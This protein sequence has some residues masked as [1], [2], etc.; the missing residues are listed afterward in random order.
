MGRLRDL[1][2]GANGRSTVIARVGRA[3]R[4]SFDAARTTN[5]N[6]RHWQDADHLSADAALSPEVRHRLRI[7]TRHECTNNPVAAGIIDTLVNDVVASGPQ[8]QMQTDDE[9]V[10]DAVESGWES[11]GEEIDLPEKLRVIEKSKLESGEV[12][13]VLVR[14]DQLE[15][16][17]KLDLRL[18]E[19]D[20][21]AT[22][23]PR[24]LDPMTVDGLQFDAFGN[25]TGYHVLKFHPG[26]VMNV[27]QREYDTFPARDVIHYFRTM[28]P[29]QHRGYPEL[30]P[31]L[32]MLAF[33]R[34]YQLASIR[35]AEAV[36]ELGAIVL[37]TELPP[38]IDSDLPTPLSTIDLERG[39]ITTL[40]F[41]TKA[42]QMRPE[43]PAST[44]DMVERSLIRLVA[45]P[46]SMPLNVALCD[47]SGYNY[48]SGRLDHQTYDRGIQVRQESM[49]RK[50]CTRI[51]RA[52]HSEAVL[53]DGYLPQ[54]ARSLTNR[55]PA[56][57]WMW[58]GRDHVDPEKEANAFR[59]LLDAKAISLAEYFA[60]KRKDWARILRQI[61]R[62]E[63]Y[64]ASLGLVRVSTGSA[65]S[66]PEES[67]AGE[68]APRARA[69]A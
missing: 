69:A 50:V 6:R 34:R 15:H 55:R 59:T 65:V 19:A 14:N 12:F 66:K 56:H 57:I 4:A 3:I 5:E 11:W 37:E 16:P 1:I 41:G 22:P 35:A 33:L 42:S 51:F 27:L 26:S 7:R 38:D 23:S 46:F 17:V 44:H 68:E 24:M 63:K 21:V 64:M 58:Q 62:E 52:F 49:G 43:Q 47:S 25:V 32:G 60:S 40:P 31:S 67:D 53:V 29:S 2:F 54:R 61:A 30:A 18:I 9:E 39:M 8:L 45:R 20:Q 13:G 48:A 36:A 10:N 28:R